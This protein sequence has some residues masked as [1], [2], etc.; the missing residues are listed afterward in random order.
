MT[1]KIPLEHHGLIWKA[2]NI[3]IWARMYSKSSH[4]LPY[5]IYA[6]EDCYLLSSLLNM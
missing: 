3:D 1:R 2:K 6:V 4:F 5:S